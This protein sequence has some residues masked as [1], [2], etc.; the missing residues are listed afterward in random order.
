M[1]RAHRCVGGELWEPNR[2]SLFLSVCPAYSPTPEVF[3]QCLCLYLKLVA[4]ESVCLHACEPVCV[5]V[6]VC[7]VHVV[8]TAPVVC[9]L[10]SYSVFKNN[11][12]FFVDATFTCRLFHPIQTLGLAHLDDLIR[13]SLSPTPNKPSQIN[14]NKLCCAICG[15]RECW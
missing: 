6:W 4:L 14:Q 2:V 15:H 8:F 3:F 13:C 1:N 5:W 11:P 7:P 10:G 9:T 12:Q